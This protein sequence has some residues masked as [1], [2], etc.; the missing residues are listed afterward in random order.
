M[1]ITMDMSIERTMRVPRVELVMAIFCLNLELRASGI[2]LHVLAG[3]L[4]TRKD[5]K[6]KVKSW[7]G[8]FLRA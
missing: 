1:N 2:C 3:E 5:I 6:L 4:P 7:Q 8:D